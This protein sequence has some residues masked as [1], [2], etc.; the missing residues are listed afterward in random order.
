MTG[1]R[2]WCCCV[3]GASVRQACLVATAG[4]T[5]TSALALAV[6]PLGAAAKMEE[7]LYQLM[8]GAVSTLQAA[9]CSLIGGHS[10]EGGEMALGG[11]PVPVESHPVCLQ[12]ADA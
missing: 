1:A 8:A 10:S 12:A 4:A 5:P 3:V 7:D 2:C 9:G 6:V 11:L